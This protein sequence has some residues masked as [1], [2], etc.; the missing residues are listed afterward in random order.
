[1]ADEIRQIIGNI[2]ISQIDIKNSGII[3]VSKV[4]ISKDLQL[5][6]ISLSFLDSKIDSEELLQK[7]K[8]LTKTIR[9]HLGN[10]LNSKFVPKLTFHYDDSLKKA[11]KINTI[12]HSIQ[13]E[14]ENV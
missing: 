8:T 10:N 6:K 11:E 9:F 3:T 12:L 2:F 7:I 5:A 13:K 4:E 14:E 1:M